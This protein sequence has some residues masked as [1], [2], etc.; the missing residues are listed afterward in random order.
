MT[1]QEAFDKVYDTI[2]EAAPNVVGPLEEILLL[3]ARLSDLL[4][5]AAHRD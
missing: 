5:E 3:M 2:T 1:P 4:V